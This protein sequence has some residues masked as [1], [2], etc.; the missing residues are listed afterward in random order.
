MRL[1]QAATSKRITL[2]QV[3]VQP[4]LL[5]WRAVLASWLAALPPAIPEP[6]RTCLAALFDWLM[7]PCLRAAT[8]L[9]P[10]VLPVSD[11]NLVSSTIRLLDSVL[12]EEYGWVC[13]LMV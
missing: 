6:S 11:I 7:P 2:E 12:L 1:R 8:R 5:G 13:S 9:M 4:D 10:T 3:Y